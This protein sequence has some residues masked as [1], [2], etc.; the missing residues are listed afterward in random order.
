MAQTQPALAPPPAHPEFKYPPMTMPLLVKFWGETA[1]FNRPE[2]QSERMSY[3]VPTP[4]AIRGMLEALYWK[5][6]F[7]WRVREIR[8]LNPIRWLSETRNE[9][10]VKATSF[11]GSVN[12]LVV[13]GA[14]NYRFQRHTRCLYD[15]AYVVVAEAVPNDFSVEE[16]EKHAHIFTERVRLGRCWS[17]PYFGCREH[18]AN[19]GPAD[20]SEPPI[21]VT[22]PLGRMVFDQNYVTPGMTYASH[23]NDAKPVP[24]YFDARLETGV[25]HVPDHLYD[26]CGGCRVDRTQ[27]PLPP[28]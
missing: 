18:S 23:L 26:V 21:P 7:H 25:V 6:Q 16:L 15:V 28:A 20:G 1:A 3:P 13:D 10:A 5:P 17:H 12:P 2:F 11:R 24:V 4:S 8:V 22:M 19:F 9:V 14:S 27:P